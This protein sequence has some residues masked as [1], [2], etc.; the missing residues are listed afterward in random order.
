M[1]LNLSLNLQ[2]QQKMVM[3]MQMHQAF[4]LLQVT[5]QELEDTLLEEIRENPALELEDDY[6]T[7]SDKEREQIRLERENAQERLEERNG[8]GEEHDIDWD[9]LIEAGKMVVK[10]GVV[11][12][13]AHHDL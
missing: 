13:Y 12:G 11:G 6:P 8:V 3:T 9:T 4:Q 2:Q 7:L 10:Q 1:S 5:G